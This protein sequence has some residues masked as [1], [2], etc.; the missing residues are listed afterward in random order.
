[1]IITVTILCRITQYHYSTRSLG[2][3][4]LKQS[5]GFQGN[6]H[7]WFFE[8]VAV[9]LIYNHL[10]LPDFN[11]LYKQRQLHAVHRKI[12]SIHIVFPTEQNYFEDESKS[13]YHHSKHWNDFICAF[14]G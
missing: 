8:Q 6:D 1:M 5:L 4:I 7:G 2:G 3:P 14:T 13:H 10:P 11:S 12:K 9:A